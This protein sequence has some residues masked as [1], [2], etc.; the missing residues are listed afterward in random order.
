MNND[1]RSDQLDLTGSV[2]QNIS[3]SQESQTHRQEISAGLQTLINEVATELATQACCIYV[4]NQKKQTL[5]PLVSWS[6]PNGATQFASQSVGEGVVGLAAAAGLH[7]G[8]QGSTPNPVRVDDLKTD[9]RFETTGLDHA[10]NSFL[11]Q[12]LTAPG[13]GR[14]LGVLLVADKVDAA[15]FSAEDEQQL[16]DF[17]SRA[18]LT[19]A[20]QNLEL[21]QE[22]QQWNAGLAIVPYK[23]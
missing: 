20:L 6:M 5:T 4:L 19:L 11:A 3:L 12:P 14:V 22:K 13:S 15:V 17:A 2:E 10:H 9:E 21:S 23:L 8:P 16:I 18:E 7:D 1:G